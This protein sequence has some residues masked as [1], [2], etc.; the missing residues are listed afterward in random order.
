MWRWLQAV[1]SQE[2][3]RFAF[4]FAL[5]TVIS[6]AQTLGQ[7]GAEALFLARL[8]AARLPATFV[9]ASI[10]TVLASFAY[11][12]RVG[13]LRN[14]RVFL[15]VFGVATA[16]V[17][18]A[19]LALR[20]GAALALPV[21]L[22]LYFASQAVL[23]S[24]FWSFAGDFFDTLAAKRLVPLFTVGMS[25]GG[26]AGGALATAVIGAFSAQ[27]LLGAWAIGLAASAALVVAGRSR[28]SRWRSL[29]AGE[30][31]EG[32]VA[33]IRAAA[34]YVR[35]SPLGRWLIVSA[36]A[37]VL[38][39]FVAQ[40]LYSDVIARAFP[41][42]AALARFLGLYLA[43]SNL[44]EVAVEVA[45]TPQLIR[46]VGVPTANL[47]HPVLTAFSFAAL[48]ASYRLPSG[49]LARA[50]RELLDNALSGPVRNLVYNALSFRFRSRVR[51]FLEGIVVYSGMSLAGVVLLATDQ[52]SPHWLCAI[53]VALA[54]LYFL[55]NLRVRRA[56]L[57]AIEDELREGRLD[58]A[59]VRAELGPSDLAQ[60]AALFEHLARE[61]ADAPS[62]A[63]L[64]LAPLLVQHGF[65]DAVRAALAHPNARLR[66][67][68]LE[69]L[70]AA[71]PGDPAA[72]AAL[73]L[74]GLSDPE[75]TVR[76]AA[77]RAL[78]APVASEASVGVALRA[79]LADP[80]PMVRAEAARCAGNEGVFETML[81]KGT[82]SEVRC[83][84]LALPDGMSAALA[85]HAHERAADP[86]PR[87]RAAALEALARA[88][89]Q[90]VS[91]GELADRVVDSSA[92][93]RRAAVRVHAARP[94]SEDALATALRDAS[95]DVRTEA[96]RALSARGAAGAEAAR[97]QLRAP[98]ESAVG[99]ALR[100][101]AALDA[102][103]GRALLRAEY[104]SRVREAWEAL[105]L[106]RALPPDSS[107]RRRFL[108]EACA[109]AFAR[110]VRI[111]FRA[112]ARLEDERVVRSVRRVLRAGGGRGRADAL[113]V[114]S[115]LGDREASR[116]L[117]L[118]LERIPI[119]E[120]L[121]SLLDV[122]APPRSE[123]EALARA[124]ALESP[125]VRLGAGETSESGALAAE[126]EAIMER[127]L[128]LR[129]VSL[130]A[131]LSLERL[132]AIERITSDAEYVKG[133]VI[134]REG[135]PGDDLY[136]LVEGE[137]H[138]IKS[139]GTPEE[140]H[141]NTLGPGS[142][143]GEMA[144]LDG[145]PR[146]ATVV[147]A[148]EARALV[149]QGARLRE[150]VQDMPDLAFDLFR[151]LTVRLRGVEERLV[152]V[153]GRGA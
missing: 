112:L 136:L 96:V 43:L 12:L 79:C 108:H 33:G 148:S 102:A 147:A 70:G 107:P 9:A 142:Y 73:W 130:F 62:E 63:L 120:K 111:A 89:P 132:Q 67:A 81:E 153:G 139:V 137:V 10:V 59:E 11:A 122:A 23:T 53:G 44:V 106:A 78:P 99:A 18:A 40:Y 126:R 84:L 74:G 34:R 68:C 15:E 87:L 64:E 31:D 145:S 86:D 133:E 8:G 138:V 129:Q 72:D 94:G 5:G 48:F 28:F 76:C 135:D 14:D 83:A 125:W 71:S 85:A 56:Y 143:F 140:E 93:V 2:R 95:R 144:V 29:S 4:F 91:G 119:E 41:D 121:A 1:R 3:G 128:S 124:R 141:L 100:V 97:A 52:L 131:G 35:R 27:S 58:L 105:L 21:L 45:V 61:E 32:S 116:V 113:E 80:E 24:H 114:V 88:A 42:E 98:E 77:L 20:A 75:A 55:A 123:A 90:S 152:Q 19:A 117:V 150:L 38:A 65:A 46:R 151:V 118:L 104:G 26:A 22:C 101:L 149:L 51:A 92:E 69:A 6:I 50:N 54:A 82:P 109:D 66:A 110:S 57:G 17:I 25:L 47:V 115:H 30:E 39:L 134:M 13:R 7:A 127:L 36:T 16:C 49:V 37:M 60:L 146:S 103:S